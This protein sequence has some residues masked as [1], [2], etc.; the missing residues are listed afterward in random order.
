MM[1]FLS[2]ACRF[3]GTT[4]IILSVLILDVRAEAPTLSHVFP[5]GGQRGT[6][7]AAKLTGK[8]PWPVSV[9]APGV[10]ITAG[11]ESGEIS[12]AIPADLAADRV[13][14]RLHNAEGASSTVPFLIGNLKEIAETEPNNAPRAAQVLTENRVT[15]NGLLKGADV[16]GFSIPLEAGQNLV[17]SVD[18]NGKLGS[19]MDAILQVC[20]IDGTVLVENHDDTGLDPRIIFPVKKT[21]PHLVRVFGYSSTPNTSIAFQGSETSF[22]RLT[23][24]TGPYLTH[25][26]PLAASLT[27]SGT[28]EL[29]GWNLPPETRLPVQPWGGERL[30]THP[31]LEPL[32]EM[33][34]SST[35]RLG[36]VFGPDFAG[37]ARLRLV[38]WTSA[39]APAVTN[40]EPTPLSLPQS[41]TACLHQPR[42]IDRYRIA[43]KK[44]DTLLVTVESRTL[45]LPLDPLV[46][47]MS[48]SGK[49]AV[50]VDDTGNNRDAVL[51]HKAAEDGDYILTVTDR[52][53]FG[54][55][56]GFYLLTAR[57]EES[58]FELTATEDAFVVSPDK[59]GEVTIN[60]VRRTGT[61]GAIGPIS[62]EAIDLPPGVTTAPVVSEATGPTEK[63]VALKL[64]TEGT[65]FSGRIR[66]RGTATAPKE[67]QRFVRAP[68]KLDT[69]FDTF[70][71][72]SI[73]KTP[74]AESQ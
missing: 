69:A 61:E 48:P 29:V 1:C 17:A 64:T 28:A 37:S 6:T 11:T 68:A 41:L 27:E 66:F 62:I 33:R 72:T 56:R 70:W 19:P 25:A 42:Q 3:A 40:N 51:T 73:E 22:Y 31:E 20:A 35:A 67:L 36:F 60:V 32:G 30:A 65:P 12:I 71:L 8:F 18:A 4:A 63:K 5:P 43:M 55:D 21:G 34:T 53:R 57:L 44:G 52:H 45:D 16:D 39:I 74:T 26:R 13:W 9:N 38:P 7:V 49:T 50:D 2:F 24:T 54:G 58:D 46:K 10:D 15:I 47:L 23:L 59:P 14:L